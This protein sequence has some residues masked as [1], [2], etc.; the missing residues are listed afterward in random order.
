MDEDLLQQLKAELGINVRKIEKIEENDVFQALTSKLEEFLNQFDLQAVISVETMEIN[1]LVESRRDYYTL[2]QHPCTTL[3][4]PDGSHLR[5]SP[6][7]NNGIEITRVYVNEE[8]RGEG[9]GTT[10][11]NTFISL[12]EYTFGYLPKMTLECTG[13]VGIGEGLQSTP[14]HNQIKFFGNFGFKVKRQNKG[15]YVLMELKRG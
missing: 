8:N 9:F 13:A 3:I 10:L 6:D 14:I 7:K 1:S 15:G 12:C 11:M 5:F 4:L 2:K